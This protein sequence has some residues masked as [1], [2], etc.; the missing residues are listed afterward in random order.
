M[1]SRHVVIIVIIK[2]LLLRRN[3]Y[4]YG[5]CLFVDFF[6]KTQIILYKSACICHCGTAMW[7]V[8]LH[9]IILLD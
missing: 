4:S 3:A 6:I 5:V 7:L 1:Q 9:L 2:L 8:Q